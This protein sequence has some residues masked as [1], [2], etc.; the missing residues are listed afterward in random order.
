VDAIALPR[1]DAVRDKNWFTG[2]G[3]V[4]QRFSLRMAEASKAGQ[5]KPS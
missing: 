3:H 5:R 4:L 2:L 1:D